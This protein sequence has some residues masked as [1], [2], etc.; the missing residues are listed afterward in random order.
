[1]LPTRRNEELRTL[2]AAYERG[3]ITSAWGLLAEP[4]SVAG[5]GP[6]RLKNVVP[7][8]RVVLVG[9]EVV[10]HA[11]DGAV[12][13]RAAELL[14]D[15]HLPDGYKVNGDAS[16]SLKLADNGEVASF[17]G[18][19]EIDLL[20]EQVQGMD[21]VEIKSG[22]TVSKDFFKGLVRF[23]DRLHDTSQRQSLRKFKV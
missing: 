10:R 16:S 12:H 1:M 8:D 19:N 7:G 21:A 11:R 5:L 18:G 23:P 13:P 9:G 17:P 2:E 6:F 20:I 4:A 15:V 22:A 3:E 14:L